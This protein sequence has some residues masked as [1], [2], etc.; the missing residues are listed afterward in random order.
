MTTKKRALTGLQPTGKFHLG[1]LL[2]ALWPAAQMQDEYDLFICVVDQHAITVDYDRKALVQNC[3]HSIASFLAAGIDPNKTTIFVQSDVP[4]HTE[5]AWYLNCLTPMGHLQRMT[6]FKEKKERVEVISSGLFTYP[7]LQAADILV[8]KAKAVPIGEDQGQHLELT[9]E[10][11]R[12]FNTIYGN[13]FPEPESLIST[14][15]PRIMSL[16]DPTKKM[17][18][19]LEGSAVCL[20]DPD[21]VIQKM[22]KRAVTDTGPQEGNNMSPG[23]ANLFTL[24][25]A[26]ST[27]DVFQHFTKQHAEGGLRY[28]E[29][30]GQLCEDAV[31]GIKPIRERILELEHN[32][33]ELETI[34]KNGAQK[35]RTVAQT[36]LQEVRKKMGIFSG[37]N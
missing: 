14:A 11:T 35:A 3:Y 7:V 15:A 23:V 25:K 16:N 30:K 2:G 36:T 34:I 28:S 1:N 17:S 21:N 24:L 33:N 5:L 13:T 9:R 27:N 29:L 31:A 22:I 19:S 6:Q 26:F 20:T 12:R 32:H 10:I 8:Y 37:R 4:E 18:K